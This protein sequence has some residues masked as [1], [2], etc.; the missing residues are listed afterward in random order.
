[1]PEVDVDALEVQIDEAK[2]SGDIAKANELYQ[3][4]IG[5]EDPFG[6]EPLPAPAASVAR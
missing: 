4:Q 2:A 6:L 3:K 5:N 1:M